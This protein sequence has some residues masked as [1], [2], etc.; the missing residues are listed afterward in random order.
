MGEANQYLLS[1]EPSPWYLLPFSHWYFKMEL[2]SDVL[3][4][5][6]LG[7][8]QPSVSCG[9]PSR[10][11]SACGAGALTIQRKSSPHPR[12][13]AAIGKLD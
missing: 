11:G 6:E 7:I 9:I 3:S 4:V 2:R 12:R 5:I 1:L 13:P 10:S 8:P